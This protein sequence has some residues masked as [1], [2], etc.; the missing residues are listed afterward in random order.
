MVMKTLIRFRVLAL[1]CIGSSVAVRA[2]ARPE[3]LIKNAT[4]MTVARG[5]F[6]NTDILI[7]NGKIVRIGKN[8]SGGSGA[9]IIDATG[10][11]VTPGIID[12]HSHT[13]I[14]GQV[15]EG[16]LAVTSMTRVTDVITPKDIA[17][18]RALAGGVTSGLLLHG[19]ANPIGGQS[20]TVK[21]KYGR[22]SAEF[23]VE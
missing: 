14:D 22:P 12:A 7:R 2:Q 6:D 23:L 18:Y 1:L 3:V 10:K 13:M 21:F 4:V 9:R 20:T 5:T 8:L 17:I 11:F 16:T 19:S 15:N